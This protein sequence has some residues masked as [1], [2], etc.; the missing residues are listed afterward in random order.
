MQ[1]YKNKVIIVTGASRG[2]GEVCS[3]G[4]AKEGGKVVLAD[5]DEVKGKEV[6]AKIKRAGGEAVFIRTD[7][8]QEK[9]VAGM[10]KKAVDIFGKLDCA[11]NNAGVEE[12]RLIVEETEENYLWQMDTNVKGIFFCMKYQIPEMVKAGGGAILNHASITSYISGD[13]SG[14]IYGASKGAVFRSG[15]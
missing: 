15:K 4:F 11:F 9:E 6:E 12:N 10:V 8:R 7:V 5:I 3:L 1:R 13:A 2:C 14:S